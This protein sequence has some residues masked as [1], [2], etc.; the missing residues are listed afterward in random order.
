VDLDVR[1]LE[2][3]HL[4]ETL[5]ARADTV[6]SLE[7]TKFQLKQSLNERRHEIAVH[8][9]ALSLAHAALCASTRAAAWRVPQLALCTQ[10][11]LALSWRALAGRLWRPSSSW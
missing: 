2:V 3:Q 11:Q 5:N 8:K 7:N 1:K 4:R 10:P 6:F 9:C